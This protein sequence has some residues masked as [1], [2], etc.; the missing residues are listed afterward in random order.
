MTKYS[1]EKLKKAIKEKFGTVAS[2][3]EASGLEPSTVS[4]LLVR[5]DW[6]ASQM[7]PALEALDIPLSEVGAYFFDEERAI[8]QPHEV[9]V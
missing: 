3:A 7:K 8:S 4:R 2:F 5:G 6:K 1:T 9:E